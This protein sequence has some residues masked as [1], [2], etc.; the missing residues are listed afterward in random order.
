MKNRNP[1]P[2]KQI[3]IQTI[4]SLDLS[5]EL[6]WQKLSQLLDQSVPFE[7]HRDLYQQ[8]AKQSKRPELFAAYVPTRSQIEQSNLHKAGGYDRLYEESIHSPETYWFNRLK[9]L[10]ISPKSPYLKVQSGTAENPLWFDGMTLNIA[11][12]CFENRDLQ[13]LAIKWRKEQDSQIQT[14]TLGDLKTHS[15]K[16][17][18]ALKAMG[19]Q[20]G[21]AWAIDM[22]MTEKSV[23][24]Y[25]GIILA[26]GVVVSIAD[27]F[28]SNEIQTRLEIA[29]AKG[30]F[31]QDLII[32]GGKRL[33][34]YEKVVQAQAQKIIVL[35]A[36][37]Q[38][39]L[40]LRQEDLS[41]DAFLGLIASN[42]D[43]QE[44]AHFVPDFVPIQTTMNILF[45]SGT[46]GTP[47]AIPWTHLT[48]IKAAADGW[49]H[50]DIQPNQVVAWPTNLGWMMGPWLI[51]ATLLNNACIALYEGNPGAKDFLRF[52][53][54]ANVEMLGIV[55]S[56][57]KSWRALNGFDGLCLDRLRAFS[58][59]GEASAPDDYFWLMS[60]VGYRPV[61]EYCGGTEIGGGYITGTVVQ[62]Q[63]PSS[64]STPAFGTKFYLL[65][66]Q[67]HCDSHVGEIALVAPILGSS[68]TLL[69]ANHQQIYFEG[70]PK[71]AQGETLR[72][73]G[74]QIAHLGNGYY[75][76]Q[77]RVDDAMNLGGIKVSSAEIERTCM[78]AKGIEDL[79]AIAY[80]PPHG[81][82]S[83]LV[84]AIVAKGDGPDLDELQG[85]IKRQLNPLF[86]IQE[87]WLVPSLPRTASNK[88][89]RRVLR[90]EYIDRKRVQA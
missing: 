13:R 51:F 50:Q 36:E 47:K 45:S 23:Y 90:K 15:I 58:S 26:G 71:G 70:M 69:N 16:V 66:D 81:G 4:L 1:M 52:V 35:P 2:S 55:P 18:L 79:A 40:P 20:A 77:G 5:P 44:I 57:V 21:D 73:H 54:D 17:A 89:M 34:L 68:Q 24:L 33:P 8:L 37:D 12:S 32:R 84:L 49:A 86:K 62:P 19:L 31:T 46:T 38:I 75:R 27:S 11:W 83:E 80:D 72:R 82:P 88:V 3:E 6:K 7:T 25:L 63:I 78:G 74:D 48:P 56:L 9:D 42:V 41:F 85:L 67:G 87:I 10:G 53:Q 65:D 39:T 14:M 29:N 30:V 59:T 64:F 76:A 61:I 60:Q 22:P 28:A 43:A